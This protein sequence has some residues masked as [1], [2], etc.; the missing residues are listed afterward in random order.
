MFKRIFNNLEGKASPAPIYVFVVL[1]VV[2]WLTACNAE[3]LVYQQ[4]TPT[5]ASEEPAPTA[6]PTGRGSGD[7]LKLLY[8]QA[9][10][11]LNPHLTSASQD[12]GAS[13]ITYE[14]LAS[15][16]KE[17][18]LV[19]FLA[20][21]I[22]SLDNGDLS[23]DGKSVIW[24]LRQDVK[25]SDGEPF[26]ADDVLFTYEFISNPAVGASSAGVY[27]TVSSVEVIDDYTV[28]V[29]FSDVNPAWSL[30][31]VGP[32][33]MIIPRHIFE[34]Y[35]GP[36]AAEAPANILPVGTGPYRVLPPGIKIQEVLFL[37]NE[38]VDTNKIVFE[39]NPFFREADKPFFSRVEL[40]GGGTVKEAARLA[41]QTGEVDFAWNLQVDAATLSELEAEGQ[42]Q[43]IPVPQSFVERIYFNFTDPNRIA[44][45]GERSSLDFP[46]PFF[47][48]L[49]VRQAFAYAVDRGTIAALY[50][51][52][53]QPTS[54]I[55]VSP[56]KYNS[57]NTSF[58]F[59]LEKTAALL[60]E[61]GWIDT[62]NN[63]VRDKDGKEMEVLFQTSANPLRQETQ[64]IIQRALRSIGVDVEIKVIDS[65]SFFDSDPNNP[66]TA[67]H[68]YA[69]L[70]MYNDGNPNPD[71]GSYMEYL[72]TDQIPQKHNNWTGE[73]VGRWQN[74]EYDA[75]YRQSTT[76]IDPD[77][78][79]QLFI[80]MN[81]KIIEDVAVIPLVHRAR[82]IGVNPNLSGVD[83]TPWDAELW[84]IKDWR[85]VSK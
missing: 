54:N 48:D 11:T 56:A 72:T 6:E 79:T 62:N 58:E 18:N 81:D 44:P 26:T 23:E 21:K 43:A 20:A 40:R 13:R 8:W 36:N 69:D 27:R 65:G 35:N 76:E 34:D 73:N 83:P 75:L 12:W 53:F 85:L 68:F 25:W 39:P 55:L 16:D 49:K 14:P 60:D 4:A 31:F 24:N 84:N 82:V 70:Q 1:V 46:H 7:V 74:P 64:R 67:Y 33:G 3:S 66:N 41:L 61:A 63:G 29:N 59:N 47:S 38:L 80:Q 30:P 17:G 52:A 57:P 77:Q 71:P 42:G 50:G 9:P 28:K 37:G 32:T 19:P 51:S 15:F 78:R 22:P 45:N 10:S 2:A 5:P